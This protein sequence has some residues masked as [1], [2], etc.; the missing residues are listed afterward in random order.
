MLS[1]GKGLPPPHRW[2]CETG[3]SAGELRAEPRA[4]R[5]VANT[6]RHRRRRD[7]SPRGSAERSAP[8]QLS[9]ERRRAAFWRVPSIL[10]RISW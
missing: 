9:G 8:P 2:Q 10:Y 4:M 3:T 7:T 5:L 6:V 1:E